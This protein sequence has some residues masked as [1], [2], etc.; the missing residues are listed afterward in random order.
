MAQAML[1]LSSEFVL[2]PL[3][4][5]SLVDEGH[6]NDPDFSHWT[7]AWRA[8]GRCHP[9]CSINTR[10]STSAISVLSVTCPGRSVSQPPIWAHLRVYAADWQIAFYVGVAG[11]KEIG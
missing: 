10:P 1:F 2:W 3:C 9:W 7:K 4:L 11:H 5:S 8:A 6:E